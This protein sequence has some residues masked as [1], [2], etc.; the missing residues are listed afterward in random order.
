MRFDAES[1]NDLRALRDL[2]VDRM[3]NSFTS[4]EGTGGGGKGIHSQ[5]VGRQFLK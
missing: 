3:V 2:L 1:N 4:S 5:R